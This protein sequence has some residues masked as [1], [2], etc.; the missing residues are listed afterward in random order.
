MYLMSLTSEDIYFVAG[1]YNLQHIFQ[2]NS[3]YKKSSSRNR[4]RHWRTVFGRTKILVYPGLHEKK[5]TLMTAKNVDIGRRLKL[6][7]DYLLSVG[8]SSTLKTIM[9]N[10]LLS[11]QEKWFP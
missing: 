1:V 4:L 7:Y 2:K 10:T 3:T 11:G 8:D 9:K 6:L 5:K